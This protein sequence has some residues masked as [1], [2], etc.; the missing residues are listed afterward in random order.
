LIFYG[1]P[2]PPRHLE[3][4]SSKKIPISK[5]DVAGLIKRMLY[6][7]KENRKNEVFPGCFIE[8]KNLMQLINELKKQGEEI[9]ILDKK[10][11]DIRN[12]K[13]KK[14]CVFLL[15]DHDGLPRK[16]LKRLKKQ[17]KFISIGK[18]TYFTS[19]TIVIVNNE[20]DRRE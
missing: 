19:Q 8:K 12:M 15:G 11:E 7:Y 5:K 4:D 16:E 13:L 18:K 1:Q 3:F 20:L 10:G 2:T 6:K 14:K 9:Y 17:C